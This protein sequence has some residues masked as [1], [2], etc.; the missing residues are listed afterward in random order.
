MGSETVCL[1]I[2][3]G[4]LT[5][6]WNRAGS[7]DKARGGGFGGAKML[8]GGYVLPVGLETHRECGTGK[9]MIISATK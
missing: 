5:Y 6:V 1:G 2:W 7:C 3:R 8:R 4:S 9:D